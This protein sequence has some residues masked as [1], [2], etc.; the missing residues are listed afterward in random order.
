MEKANSRYNILASLK[1]ISTLI[2]ISLHF[3]F[4][5]MISLFTFEHWDIFPSDSW[6]KACRTRPGLNGELA[7]DLRTV[8]HHHHILILILLVIILILLHIP[9]L[10]LILFILL[11]I[12]LTLLL[13]NLLLLLLQPDDVYKPAGAEVRGASK[14]R[15]G[16]TRPREGRSFL[17]FLWCWY[18]LIVM[19]VMLIV[20]GHQGPSSDCFGRCMRPRGS[21]V[22]KKTVFD[23]IV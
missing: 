11:Q 7:R 18:L 10:L 14:S 22:N 3:H 13:I 23:R 19:L 9:L 17:F 15:G 6:R 1:S 2:L 21:H 4:C 16:G 5:F 8:Y 20:I 12:L